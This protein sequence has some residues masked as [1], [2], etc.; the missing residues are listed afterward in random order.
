MAKL[1]VYSFRLEPEMGERLQALADE[2]AKRAAGAPVTRSH[3]ARMA[4]ERGIPA[5]EEEL[6]L[7][8]RRKR[9]K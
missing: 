6:G 4:V 1:T 9:K 3:V 7:N 2:L 8:R 5:L